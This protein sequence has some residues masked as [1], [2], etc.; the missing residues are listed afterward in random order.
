MSYIASN[1]NRLYAEVEASY[2]L[3]AAAGRRFPAVR[4]AARQKNEVAARRDKT[5]T[6]TF[7]GPPSGVRRTTTYD[8]RTYLTSWSDQSAAP[9]YGALI[10]AAL[11]ADPLFYDGGTIAVATSDPRLQFSA[12]HGL[13]SGQAVAIGGELRFVTVVVDATTVEVN[14]PFSIAPAAGS[15][16]TPTVTY[17]PAKA[18][19]S[20][21]VCDFWSPSSAVQRV[22]SGMA[23]NEFGI[24][25][26]ADYHELDFSGPAADVIDSGTFQEGQGGLSA[27]PEEPEDTSFDYSVIPGHLGQVW[28][29]TGPDRF[30][31]LTAAK[32][33]L[34]N[35]VEMRNREFGSSIPRAVV[36]GDREVVADF[37][38]YASD[39][40][41]T[42]ALYEAARNGAA[43]RAMFQLGEQQGQLFGA[44]MKS[45]MPNM[46]E[47]DESESR[48]SWKFSGCRAQGTGEDELVVAFG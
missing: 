12:A 15:P 45:L 13:V 35:H 3:A 11:G 33:R 29:G 40:E 26:N 38:L 25:V 22:L 21:T 9:G 19:K 36:A 43:V 4:L 16:A 39:D 42:R 10:E 5:G 2:G 18:L 17:K 14:A 47:F 27:F 44:Y 37:E 34:R 30:Y 31:T 32:I 46:P 20:A 6:R 48:L 28:L 23:V 24:T 7:L 41:Q 8:L 1:D